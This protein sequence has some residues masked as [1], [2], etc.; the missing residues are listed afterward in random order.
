[1][2][3]IATLCSLAFCLSTLMGYS[4]AGPGSTLEMDGSSS[5]VTCGTM[6]YS[7]SDFTFSTWVKVN[8]FES[9]FP[10]ITS[11]IG[12]QLTSAAI[13]RI[14]DAGVPNDQPQFVIQING[15]EEKLESSITL[16]TGRWYH[17]AA[18]YDG[19]EMKIYVNGR[20]GGTKAATGTVAF[21]ELIALGRNYDDQRILDG[22]LDE[23]RVWTKALSE[24]TIRTWMCQ[25]I[26]TAHPD[27]ADLAGYWKL[28]ENG[29]STVADLGPNGFNG[30]FVGNPVWVQSGAPIGDESTHS[31]PVGTVTL[32]H[33]N[34]DFVTLQNINGN[35]SGVH[36]YRVDSVPNVTTAPVGLT[37]IDTS[38]YWG[39]FF[40]NGNPTYD[41]D[42]AFA[43]N[44]T[45]PNP[46]KLAWANRASAAATDWQQLAISSIN[47]T[48][49]VLKVSG[50]GSEEHVLAVNPQ[51]VINLTLTASG[52][53]CFGD[54]N[55]T[56][57]VVPAG[58]LMP[59]AYQWSSGVSNTSMENNLPGGW[60]TVTVTDANNC[61]S[62]DSI[63]IIQPAE[64]ILTIDDTVDVT[65]EGGNDGS[66]VGAAVGG[67]FPISFLWDDPNAQVSNTAINLSE[68]SYTVVAT[69]NN[70]CT[71]SETV[72]LDF[73]NPAPAVD[74]GPDIAA[75]AAFYDL[76]APAGLATY[77]WSNGGTT[78]QIRVF[79]SG[80]YTVTV[81][82]DLSCT[83]T[84][85][86]DISK[87]WASSTG[88]KTLDESTVSVF[89]NPV[90][91]GRIE[92]VWNGNNSQSLQVSL[93]NL[94][95]STLQ[96]ET[97]ATAGTQNRF[98]ID[99][100]AHPS[101][102]YLLKVSTEQR[103]TTIR[104]VLEK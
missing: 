19:A 90:R 12:T 47:F 70:G 23:T 38:R 73:I 86:I 67:V 102:I 50:T 25:K 80:T 14:G 6:V 57:T 1:M 85:M 48:G 17:L 10:F 104:L 18:T 77:D 46:C 5:F 52:N 58:G 31:Y 35:S 76:S 16:T 87:V 51:S 59:Y 8:Q 89:P 36:V 42:Y 21:N 11:V 92:L 66:I 84:D 100:S 62:E 28:D 64:I 26:T 103:S 40:T 93:M 53:N 98:P 4:Q 71:K 61:A 49:S 95:G 15:V 9:A 43:S 83:N 63:E 79:S 74:L 24:Q 2:K 39:V 81:T 7:G 55:G 101:G 3:F 32:S 68:G 75:N 96:T 29:G 99:L 65:C 20:L 22:Q 44:P 30:T 82:D 54:Q 37:A 88:D 78:Q 27:Y 34:G 56:A 41:L 60:V 33:P 72:V 91:D 45:N 94:V 13:I 97:L 69:D